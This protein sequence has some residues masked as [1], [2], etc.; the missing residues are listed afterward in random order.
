M[1]EFGL[2]VGVLLAFT[3]YTYLILRG[4]NVFAKDNREVHAVRGRV[5]SSRLRRI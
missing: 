2:M 3:Y 4:E 1:F 5:R